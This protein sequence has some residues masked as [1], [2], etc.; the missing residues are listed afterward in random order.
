MKPN[1][2]QMFTL[3]NC[4]LAAAVCLVS[5]SHVWAQSGL[6]T[7]NTLTF[8]YI[9]NSEGFDSSPLNAPIN[10]EVGQE[11]A[12]RLNAVADK[13]DNYFLLLG[14]NGQD[15]KQSSNAKSLLGSDWVKKYIARTSHEA[16]YG[17]EKALLRESFSLNPIRIKK[18]INVYLYLSGYALS[19]MQKNTEDMPTPLLFP[20]EIIAYVDNNNAKINITVVT[21]K[22]TAEAITPEAIKN[23]FT[24]C[25]I[26][27]EQK[28]IDVE[29]MSF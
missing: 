28:N 20:K 14:V 2:K 13:A 29:I 7:F 19:Q 1:L 6:K 5:N 11:F 23:K 9:D 22:E 15:P 16:D 24:F 12:K 10:Y 17:F 3:K 26:Q 25:S 27:I 4:F 8:F 21:N 18:E